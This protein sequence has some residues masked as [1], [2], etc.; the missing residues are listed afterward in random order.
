MKHLKTGLL[1]AAI[2]LIACASGHAT[3]ILGGQLWGSGSP[4]TATILESDSG[5]S[6]FV[7]KLAPLPG[8]FIGI[9]D[10]N[11]GVPVALG[12][13]DTCEELLIG[14][15]S[16]EGMFVTGPGSRNPDGDIHAALTWIDTDSV[17][18]GFEDIYNLGD[19]DYNDAIVRLDGVSQYQVG[20]CHRCGCCPCQCTPVGG[21]AP[22]PASMALLGLGVAGIGARMRRRLKA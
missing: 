7:W 15:F 8:Q 13:F 6:N 19:A 16:P 5:F 9:D 1:I 4:T 18:I 17:E 12:T 20:N 2:A 10:T 21:C 3:P 11:V 22:E 14:I